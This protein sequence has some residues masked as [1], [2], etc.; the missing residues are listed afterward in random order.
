ML[1]AKHARIAPLQIVSTALH[2]SRVNIKAPRNRPPARSRK[3][4]EML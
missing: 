4:M 3:K 1:I 2:E